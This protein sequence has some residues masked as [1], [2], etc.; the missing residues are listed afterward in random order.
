VK[1][2]GVE[3]VVEVVERRV[4]VTGMEGAGLPMEVSRTWHVIGGFFSV[5]I[6]FAVWAGLGEVV[7][8]WE[9]AWMRCV[10]GVE[11]GMRMR[12][13]LCVELRRREGSVE[14]VGS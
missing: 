3:V 8:C 5:A 11:G 2:A 12:W 13:C 10:V 7:S 9:I 4:R 6:V 14:V 1:E